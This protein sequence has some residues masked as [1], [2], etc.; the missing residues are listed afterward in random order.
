MIGKQ[1]FPV[2]GTL[3]LQQT[4]VSPIPFKNPNFIINIPSMHVTTE[5]VTVMGSSCAVQ[6]NIRLINSR[7]MQ[8]GKAIPGVGSMQV[9][10]MGMTKPVGPCW[11][12]IRLIS[13]ALSIGPVWMEPDISSS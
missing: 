7:Y 1:I 12:L 6:V 2:L 8:L 10:V 13:V 3:M 5:L 4:I 9:T 11:Q